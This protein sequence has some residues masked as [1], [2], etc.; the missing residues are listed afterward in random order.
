MSYGHEYRLP[1]DG[2]IATVPVGY[3]DGLM[4]AAGRGARL[5]V[6]GRP[7]AIAGRV[8]MDLVMLDVTEAP[9]VREGD[10][11]VIIGA[12]GEASVPAEE[13]AAAGGTI[14]YE[15]VT[16][17]RARVPRRYFRGARHVATRTLAEGLVWR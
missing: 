3:G 15:V 5:L 13:L 7:T 11:V 17:I 9:G 10:E 4:R 12:Q 14:N 2:V 1:R 16:G 6:R 8:A